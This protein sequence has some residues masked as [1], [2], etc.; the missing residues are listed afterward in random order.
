MKDNICLAFN[1]GRDEIQN[2]IQWPPVPQLK[3]I[4]RDRKVKW[5]KQKILKGQKQKRNVKVKFKRNFKYKIP[6]KPQTSLFLSFSKEK[7]QGCII[8]DF[9]QKNGWNFS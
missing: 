1:V 5:K 2:K 3:W 9:M 6:F 7:S 4:T 8:D